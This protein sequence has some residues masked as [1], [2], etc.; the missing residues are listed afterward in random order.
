MQKRTKKPNIKYSVSNLNNISEQQRDSR[1]FSTGPVPPESKPIGTYFDALNVS[2]KLVVNKGNYFTIDVQPDMRFFSYYVT[3]TTT[4]EHKTMV[5]DNDPYVSIP[6]IIGYKLAL[7]I[8]QLL[9][10]DIHARKTKSGFTDVFESNPQ[11]SALLATLMSCRIPQDVR[12]PLEQMAP[13]KDPLRPELEFIPT[14]ACFHLPLD[15]GRT[16]PS[17]MFFLIHDFL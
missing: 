16:I 4:D 10:L 17:Y 3:T 14:L 9:V 1:T 15:F 6:S 12:I 13:V 8:G 11:L 2:N 7:F 5:I